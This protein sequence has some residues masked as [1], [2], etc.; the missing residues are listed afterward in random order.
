MQEFDVAY[1]LSSH[2]NKAIVRCIGPSGIKAG[3]FWENFLALRL[4]YYKR[5]WWKYMFAK[6]MA[7]LLT[8]APVQNDYAV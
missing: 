4:E 1:Q 2:D 8:R 6:L 5:T 3:I 7:A